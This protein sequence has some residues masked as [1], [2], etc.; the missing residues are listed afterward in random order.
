[1]AQAISYVK[2]AEALSR[3]V[4]NS[5]I[6]LFRVSYDSVGD[7]RYV[8]VKEEPVVADD[9]KLTENDIVVRYRGD[10]IVGVTIMQ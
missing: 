1:M 4:M 10:E 2:F 8:N 5:G 6:P 3:V 7:V 9:S